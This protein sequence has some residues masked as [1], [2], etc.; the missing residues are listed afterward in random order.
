[1]KNIPTILTLIFIAIQFLSSCKQPVEKQ[2]P[3]ILFAIA[4]DASWKHFGA[5]GCDWVKTPAF[6]RVAAEGILFSRAY[7]P[8]AKCAPSRS[9]ILTGRNS[10]QLEEAA[11]HSPLFPAKFKTY[12]EA[13]GENGY[14]VGSV[15]KGWAPGD[16]GEINGKKRELT[17]PKFDKYQT[18]PPAKFISNN[19]YAKN[20]EAFLE[21]RPEGK[22]FCFWYGSTEPHR[23]YEFGVGER[24]GGKTP[25]EIDGIPAFWPDVDTIR[26]DMLDYAFEIEYFDKHLQMMLQKLEEIGELEN[27]IVIVTAD[28]GMPFPRIKGQVYEYSN[29][30]PLAI[31]W[32]RGIKNPGRVVDDFVNFIDFTPTYL[33]VAGLTAEQ[34]GMQ[35]VTGKSLTDIF[36]LGEEG[37]V[38][39]ERNF[40]LVGKERHDVGRP[41]DHGY[42]VRGIIKGQFLYLRN[43]HP[44]RWPLGNPETGYLNCDGSPTK[45]YILDTR[46]KKG[47]MEYWQIN[48]GKR[49]A[50][51]LYNIIEDPFCMK[52]LVGEENYAELK[53]EMETEMVQ[54]L[55][56]QGDPRISGNG[57]IFDNYPYQGEVQNYYNRYMA[58]EK[59]KAGWVNETDYDELI[60]FPTD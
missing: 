14:W 10:W 3:N 48:F 33:E 21:A 38:T 31:M 52:N 58:G 55:T 44:E 12:A 4:D 22:P 6:D 9:C 32:P 60:E 17:G 39:P 29:H 8:N 50:E 35:P 27:T 2:R 36:N 20:F 23:A 41:D 28:N 26:T 37:E 47:V 53:L 1:M 18:E 56:E 57:D 25:S 7:T 19:D 59:V 42:P 11:N 54:K 5:Y 51:E 24:L 43:F 15:A 46:R 13:L 16:P 34:A 49:T 45:T 40:V 30:L